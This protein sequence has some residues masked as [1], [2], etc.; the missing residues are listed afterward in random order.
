MTQVYSE[1]I[2][3]LS[4]HE[5]RSPKWGRNLSLVVNLCLWGCRL[6]VALTSSPFCSMHFVSIAQY[7][8]GF[9]LSTQEPNGHKY[10]GKQQWI[11]LMFLVTC[12]MFLNLYILFH[13]YLDH[14]SHLDMVI[15][16]K[17]IKK[18]KRKSQCGQRYLDIHWSRLKSQPNPTRD[19]QL[20]HFISYSIQVLNVYQSHSWKKSV[21]CPNIRCD[22]NS[23]AS[24]H[25]SLH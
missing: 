17:G 7:S 16:H 22:C 11:L 2:E 10:S 25:H 6:P 19:L 3:I 18:L 8:K 5:Q 15:P 21:F 13:L 12:E 24:L 14:L 4:R 1:S 20:Y 9:L 23:I